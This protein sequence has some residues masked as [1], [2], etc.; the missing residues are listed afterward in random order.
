MD[1]FDAKAVAK[2]IATANQISVS[3]VAAAIRLLEE[4]N[5]LPFI[6]RYRK[7][8]TQELDEIA[9][10]AIEDELAR[11]RA[12]ATRKKSILNT[13]EEQGALTAELRRQIIACNDKALLED[14]YLP[15]KKKRRTKATIAREAGLGPLADL[16]LK[17]ERIGKTKKAILAPFIDVKNGIKTSEAALEGAGHIVAESWTQEPELR[18]W[19]FAEIRSGK[20]TSKVKRGKKEAGKKFENYYDFSEPIKRIASHRFLAIRR[21]VDE[22]FLNLGISVDEEYFLRQLKRRLVTNRDFEF[23]HD[24][25]A[26]VESSW[27]THLLP[28]ASQAVI[29]SLKETAETEAIDVFAKNM[30]ELLLAPPAGK[31]VTIGLDPGFRSGCKVAVVDETGKYLQSTVIYPTAPKNDIAGGSKVLLGLI[32]E[33]GVKMIAIGNGTASRETDAFVGQLIKKQ[34]LDITKV[35]VSESGASIYSASQVA[36]DEYPDLDITVRGAISI[37][38]RLQDPLAELV[39]IDAKSIGVGQYQ[40]DVNQAELK[41]SLDREVESCVNLVGVELNTASQHLLAYVSGIGPKTAKRIVAHRDANG[42]FD[43]KNQLLEVP[44]LGKKVF[45][46][47]AGFLRIANGKDPLDNSAVHPESHALVKKM[48]QTLDMKVDRMLGN[49]AAIAKLKAIDFVDD[50][51]GEP[52]VKDILAE[53]V[54]PGRDP[55]RQFKAVK[56]DD[57]VTQVS[58]LR[59]GM[60]LQGQVTNVTNFGAFVDIG[61]HQDGLVHVSQIAD[62]YV[63]DPAEIVSVNDIVSVRVVSV[64]EKG[65]RISLSMK[66]S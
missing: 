59:E 45:Q 1:F 61:V 12:V 16:L 28:A 25:L 47:A 11:A 8:A 3:S 51:F 18:I 31:L 62:H 66:T 14:L 39:K 64:D 60:R 7:E 41:R 65:K 32:K 20:V 19:L 38:H 21:G 43:S 13:L 9:L 4:G 22:G 53:L 57:A 46:Q 23:F 5:T 36:I 49:S 27:K 40:H 63:A 37:A 48:A 34:K 50:K 52:T 2:G 15:Y 24:L 17:Q 56:F 42:V 58:D 35:V 33:Y 29:A 6:A 44:K 54:K 55:R 10:R 26:L 30:R